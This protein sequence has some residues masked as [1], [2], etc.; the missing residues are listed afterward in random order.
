MAHIERSKVVS[1]NLRRYIKVKGLTQQQF[2]ELCHEDVT[3]LRK[4]LKNGVTRLDTVEYY[5]EMLSITIE[6]LLSLKER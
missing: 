3:T 1:E 6:D 4:Q 2:S 5:A